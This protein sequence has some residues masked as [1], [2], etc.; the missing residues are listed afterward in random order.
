MLIAII[1]LLYQIDTHTKRLR[2]SISRKKS[3]KK[4]HRILIHL[5]IYHIYYLLSVVPINI[6]SYIRLSL[7]LKPRSIDVTLIN[8]TYFCLQIYPMVIFF[9][10]R[11]QPHPRIHF[12]QEQKAAPFVIINPHPIPSDE[13]QRTRL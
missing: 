8:Y 9:L 2:L 3:R 7:T 5:G 11:T 10:E 12:S 4:F 1:Y 13:Y 6:Y